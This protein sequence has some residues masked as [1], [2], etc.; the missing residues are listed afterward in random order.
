MSQIENPDDL[1]SIAN[2]PGFF[3]YMTIFVYNGNNRKKTVIELPQLNLKFR[4]FNGLML[5]IL[6][7]RHTCQSSSS[8]SW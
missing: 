5:G 1:Q 4:F 7:T 3:V 6:G 2:H 8:L